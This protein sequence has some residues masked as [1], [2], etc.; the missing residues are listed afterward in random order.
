MHHVFAFISLCIHFP[1]LQCIFIVNFSLSSLKRMYFHPTHLLAQVFFFNFVSLSRAKRFLKVL[2]RYACL[3]MKKNDSFLHFSV[4]FTGLLLSI[5]Y[6]QLPSSFS[7]FCSSRLHF[8]L[9]FD[10][11]AKYLIICPQH[12]DFVIISI[13]PFTTVPSVI[14]N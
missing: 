9:I 11:M 8:R 4:F 2:M 1:I 7:T 10:N 14:E 12:F 13:R 6:E 5:L 3:S